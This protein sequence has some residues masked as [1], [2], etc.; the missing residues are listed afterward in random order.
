VRESVGSIGVPMGS[1]GTS[2]PASFAVELLPCLCF[3]DQR[4][5]AISTV[6]QEVA[7]GQATHV[8]GP[9]AR[10]RISFCFSFLL[11]TYLNAKFKNAYL[12]IGRSK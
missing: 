12:E 9:V 3:S 10:V 11:F 2:S 4:A 8:A 1:S 6:G 5:P 7:V